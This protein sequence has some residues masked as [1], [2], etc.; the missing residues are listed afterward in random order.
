MASIGI[1]F[2]IYDILWNCFHCIYYIENLTVGLFDE[3]L[4]LFLQR[5]IC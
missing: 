4:L 5:Q 3:T 2:V 1:V